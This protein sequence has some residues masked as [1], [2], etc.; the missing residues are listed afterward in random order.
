MGTITFY[1]GN[2]ATQTIIETV[3]DAPGQSFRPINNDEIRSLKLSA[4]R[5]GAEIHVCDNPSGATD[6]DFCTIKVKQVTPEHI[7][8][9]FERTYEDECVRVTLI[10]NGGKVSRVRIS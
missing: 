4:A 9:T 2:N 1:E 3:A 8:P 10:R 6:E 7:V 5:A